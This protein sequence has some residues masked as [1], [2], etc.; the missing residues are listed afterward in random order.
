MDGLVTLAGGL[1]V[2]AVRPEVRWLGCAALPEACVAA[3]NRPPSHSRRNCSRTK[4]EPG[5]RSSHGPPGANQSY[6]LQSGNLKAPIRVSQL[7]PE[8][9]APDAAE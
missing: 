1:V 2:V 9:W 3:T 6:F 4:S 8:G 7:A 5:G